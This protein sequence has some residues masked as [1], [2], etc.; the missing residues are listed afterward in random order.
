MTKKRQAGKNK[1]PKGSGF[2]S[3]IFG[4]SAFALSTA[5]AFTDMSLQ[6]LSADQVLAGWL[7]FVGLATAIWGWQRILLKEESDW[8]IGQDTWAFLVTFISVSVAIL[9]LMNA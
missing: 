7:F 5:L 2:A 9:A 1:K 4:L 8:L 3:L 6:H